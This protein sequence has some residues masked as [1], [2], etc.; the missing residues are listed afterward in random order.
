MRGRA[1]LKDVRVALG[2]GA[3]LDARREETVSRRLAAPFRHAP[4]PGIAG[5]LPTE[6][7]ARFEER[8]AAHGARAMTVASI[9]D[10]PSAVAALLSEAKMELRIVTGEEPAFSTLSWVAHGVETVTRPI[11]DGNGA[12]LSRALAGIAETGA[13]MLAS[14]RDNPAALAF[15]PEMHIVALSAAAI[16]PSYEA[17][18]DLARTTFGAGAMPRALNLIS[19]PS[20]TGDIGGRIV[21]GA[22]GPRRFAVIVVENW[23]DRD[24]GAGAAGA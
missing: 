9:G 4:V 10:I 16:V 15:L 13:L 3:A 19:G 11:A 8:L 2:K 5:G 6:V 7:R 24:S 20:R 12:A 14:G 21:L 23:G 17:A 1:F 22:H 18:F